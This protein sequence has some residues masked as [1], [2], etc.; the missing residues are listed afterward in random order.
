MFLGIDIGTSSVKLV[1]I[2][3]QGEVL[4]TASA[5]LSV[6]RSRENWS[7]QNPKDWWYAVNQCIE[8]IPL[9][10]RKAVAAISLSGQMHTATLID[11]HNQV[12]RPAMLWNDG[13]SVAQCHT[14]QEA[15]AKFK[16]AGANLLMPGFT[17]PKLEWVRQNEPEVFNN[18]YK[19]LLPKDYV[20]LCMCGD[21]A[22][23]MSDASGTLLLDIKKRA[24][25]SDLLSACNLES[26]HM[27]SLFEGTEITGYLLRSTA[28]KWGMSCVPVF[29]GG[30][31]NAAGALGMGAVN[32]G[33]T[34]LSLGTSGVIFTATEHFY[35]KPETAVHS[36]CHAIPKRWHLMS[37]M[38][39]AASCLDWACRLTQTTNVSELIALAESDYKPQSD[40]IF[41]PYLSGER[42]PHNNVN[43]TGVLIGLSH[44]TGPA[45]L[46]NAVLEGV[47]MGLAD[48][49]EALL[50]AGV[51][52]DS[53]RVIG[54]GARSSH[55]GSIL[56]NVLNRPLQFC[57]DATVGPAMGAAR[58]ARMLH[59]NK[60]SAQSKTKHS[61]T[62]S[63]FE[64]A[65]QAPPIHSIVEPNSAL[66]D[67]YRHKLRTFRQAYQ[68]IKPQYT[69][70]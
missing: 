69:G 23:D 66:I 17:A 39:S 19:V 12:L 64:E 32:E 48:G 24:W 29:A 46:A 18:I 4:Q 27:P 65:F 62:T 45:Q 60:T 30:S 20:R 63:H 41:L 10:M 58:L 68:R 70:N 2:S 40:L 44:D 1:L 50:T 6:Y 28:A 7:E 35:A 53:L 38:L 5:P 43:A 33:D 67:I 25:H 34:I 42:T 55:W 31:D 49:L 51:N 14:L 9:D 57:E 61:N 11:K 59:F 26:K 3:E 8:Q 56:A 47:A 15:Q 16:T 52:I 13:R 22:T 36:F 54:G 21:Y 37:V